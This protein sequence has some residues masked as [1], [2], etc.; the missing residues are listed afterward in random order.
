MKRKSFAVGRPPDL[1]LKALNK[2][3]NEK[4]KVGAAWYNR[5]GS[6]SVDLDAF[7]TLVS[8]PDLVLTLFPDEEVK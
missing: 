2:A 4:R 1:L 3:T 8:S 5:D 7:T 6:I